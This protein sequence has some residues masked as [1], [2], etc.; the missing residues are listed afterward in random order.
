MATFTQ[1][2]WKLQDLLPASSGPTYDALVND[3]KARVAA[4]ENARAQLSD[5]MDERE[6]LAILREYE[7]LGALNRKLGAYAGLWFAE[8]TQDGA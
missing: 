3:L 5:E 2:R 6:F 1:S 8:N 4:F 7:Q